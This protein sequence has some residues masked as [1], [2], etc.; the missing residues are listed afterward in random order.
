ML[1]SKSE[2]VVVHFR[3]LFQLMLLRNWILFPTVT[4]QIHFTVRQIHRDNILVFA[5]NGAYI[6]SCELVY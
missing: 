5:L 3:L 2:E 4:F 1:D 6:C